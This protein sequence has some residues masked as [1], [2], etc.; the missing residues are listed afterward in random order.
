MRSLFFGIAVVLIPFGAEAASL[1][2][3]VNTVALPVAQ[4]VARGAQRVPVLRLD[5]TAGC[6]SDVS[7]EASRPA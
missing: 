6:G 1:T 3:R 4:M 5:L 2:L 7:V